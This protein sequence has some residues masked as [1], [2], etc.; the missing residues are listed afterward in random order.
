M[1][2]NKTV[3]QV[4]TANKTLAGQL[5]LTAQGNEVSIEGSPAALKMLAEVILATVGCGGNVFAK[6]YHAQLA[7]ADRSGFMLT[8][9]SLEKLSFHCNDK[10]EG[11][12]PTV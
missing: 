2:T 6:G 8:P 10:F 5:R 12:A 11:S 9:D 4:F 3:N 1:T 7:K